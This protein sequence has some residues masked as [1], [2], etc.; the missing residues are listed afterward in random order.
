VPPASNGTGPNGYSWW[1]NPTFDHPYLNHRQHE[2][3]PGR[4]D[5]NFRQ[6]WD[7][8]VVNT[9]G[10]QGNAI[11]H[12]CD[13]RRLQGLHSGVMTAGLADGSVRTVNSTISALTWQRLCTKDEGEVLGSDW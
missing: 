5:P 2:Q 4:S 8:G 10:I 1:D 12:R 9:G 3:R 7:G 6:N 11:P 13:Y